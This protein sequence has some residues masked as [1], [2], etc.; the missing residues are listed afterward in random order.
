MV[1]VV[2]VVVGGGGEW[3]GKGQAGKGEKPEGWKVYLYWK[4]RDT[5]END[6][7]SGQH[8]DVNFLTIIFAWKDDQKVT[9]NDW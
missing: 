6:K 5:Q 7:T 3:G 8:C 9:E 4:E 1:V 2:V